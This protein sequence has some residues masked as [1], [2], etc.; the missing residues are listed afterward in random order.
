VAASAAPLDP[1]PLR[2]TVALLRS[3][4]ECAART[5]FADSLRRLAEGSSTAFVIVYAIRALFLG[6]F[7]LALVAAQGSAAW[8]TRRIIITYHATTTF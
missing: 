2:R 8:I 6:L 7:G 1:D 5:D 3:H 4:S